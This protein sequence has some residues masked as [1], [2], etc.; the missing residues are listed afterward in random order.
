[1]ERRYF[2][3]HD[4]VYIQGRWELG[5]PTDSQD[6]EVDDPWQFADGRPVRIEEP[7]RVPVTHPGTP[8]DFS[9]A[10]I[11]VTPIVHKRVAS[12]LA[13]L[14]P[15]DVQLIPV[16]LEG[17]PEP[18]CILV[19]TRAIRC[20]D[21]QASAEVKYWKPEDGQPDR[22]GEYRA[23]HGMRID[24]AK[25]GDAKVFRPW[26]WT[27][28]LIVSEDIK[29]ALERAGVTGVKFTEVTGP[30]ELS[31]E[32][33]E[34]NRK[35]IELRE[36]TDA[37]R[38]AFWRTLGRL[39]EEVIIPIV[40]GGSWP[41]RRQ[42]WRII[43]RPSGRTLLVTDGFSDYFADH[44]EPSVGFGLELALETDEPLQ[45]AEQSWPLLLLERVGDEVAEHERVREKVKTGFL[46]M[47]VSGKGLPESLVTQEGRVGVLLGMEPS[48]LP[49]A[50]SM[51]AG[52]VRLVT[53]K[54]L[55]P[56]ELAYLLEH[57]KK[58]RDELLR[59]FSQEGYG[60]L[61][62]VWRNPVV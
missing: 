18:Y 47:E 1:M 36:Q 35:L 20:I 54:V 53:V 19:A 17:Q 62:R 21:D 31:P 25:V 33:R 5:D 13:E 6:R 10:G 59:R 32:E 39:D 12:L 57:G 28:A 49:R 50:F 30:S 23:V 60:H 46:S 8:L 2:D 43:H 7:L 27:V 45:D 37:A 4:D 22:V 26:G 29:E 9:L 48:T 42:V 44:V 51:P 61:S 40:V 24:P 16:E 11:G 15:D 56:A 41:A 3:L 52:E 58:G 55:L 34:R 14:A 38:E